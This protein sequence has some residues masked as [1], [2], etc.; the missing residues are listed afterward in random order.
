MN[1]MVY[2]HA[3]DG[4]HGLE[5]WKTDGTE[6]GTSMVKDIQPGAS[7]GDPD[8]FTVFNGNLY[9][10]ANDGTNGKELWKS[11]GTSNGTVMVKDIRPGAEGSDP[12]KF[13]Q[14]NNLLLFICD[15]GTYGKE[16]WK[17]DGTESG[18][19]IVKDLYPG[20]STFSNPDLL[21]P[22]GNE[23]FFEAFDGSSNYGREWYK[24]DG[25]ETGTVLVA[26]IFP[27]LL[28]SNIAFPYNA[29]GMLYF[30][31]TN[32][33]N[34]SELWRSNGTPAGTQMVADIN[35]GSGSSGPA[36]M[37][38]ANGILY[39][40]ASEPVHGGELWAIRDV[41]T[42]DPKAS[43]VKPA[44]YPNPARDFLN[45]RLL[46]PGAHTVHLHDATGRRIKTFFF[47]GHSSGISLSDIAP[48]IYYLHGDA[49]GNLGSVVIH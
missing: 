27:G 44:L 45:I 5:L 48:G 19:R 36:F 26:D 29:D 16:I 30:A 47:K 33:S 25:T 24:T 14:V 34:G 31:A 8:F 39:F 41:I 43:M 10:V 40:I 20:N 9:F 4:T 32:G 12:L 6:Q 49:A 18:T 2:F 17:S 1:G 38:L 3:D 42:A 21:I 35:P 15:N 13:Y 28:N 7:G 22:V 37:A 23:L 46:N 11:D